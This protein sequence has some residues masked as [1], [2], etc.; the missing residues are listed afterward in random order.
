MK[1]G[2][3]HI[4]SGEPLRDFNGQV[5]TL[6]AEEDETGGGAGWFARRQSAD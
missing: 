2:A 3:D 6:T 1:G 5:M 4:D